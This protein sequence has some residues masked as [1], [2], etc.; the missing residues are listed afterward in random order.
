MVIESRLYSFHRD[1]ADG[2]SHTFLYV[3]LS[4]I[5]KE[6]LHTNP[7]ISTALNRVYSQGY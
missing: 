6:Y 1:K 2:I 4:L 7:E 3:F 5:N